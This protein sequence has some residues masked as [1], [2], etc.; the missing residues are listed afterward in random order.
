MSLPFGLGEF[1]E[2]HEF[3]ER[4]LADQRAAHLRLAGRKVEIFR[5]LFTHVGANVPAY[6]GTRW[7]GSIARTLA[8]VT[9]TSRAEVISTPDRFRV[10]ASE[11]VIVK[12]STS[13][14]TGPPMEIEYDVAAAHIVNTRLYR[15]VQTIMA[16]PSARFEPGS[17]FI[18]QVTSKPN[19]S[20]A[21]FLIPDREPR[22]LRRYPIYN[23][24]AMQLLITDN[25]P[26]LYGKPMYLR[27]LVELNA[28]LRPMAVL[29]S[30]ERLYSDDRERIRSE[31]CAPIINAYATTE[32][33]VIAV[34]KPDRSEMIV[35]PGA[36][37]EVL[38]DNGKIS[39]Q[40]D[41]EALVTS[42][43]NYRQPL[44]RYR[45]GDRIDLKTLA[46]GRQFIYSLRRMREVQPFANPEL[47]ASF[48][49]GLNRIGIWDFR[50]HLAG[51]FPLLEWVGKET[52]DACA[53]YIGQLGES[54]GLNGLCSRRVTGL[55]APGTK[56]LRYPNAS[57]LRPS[58]SLC[59]PSDAT[60]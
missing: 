46:N 25:P 15:F 27:Q 35:M 29:V 39:V 33:G 9:P 37:L 14:S 50:L 47:E 57:T 60:G 19:R 34:T 32:C 49:S 11:E 5:R 55:T 2:A 7:L 1:A 56:R 30:G 13:G 22:L 52:P 10:M 16:N 45:T 26:V 38:H 3:I 54:V 53:G 20:F 8:S 6:R 42:A 59:V 23:D 12:T 28:G 21:S 58:P 51:H 40:G 44:L 24:T 43:F 48:E 17:L 41:G 31:F 18:G 4:V 36:H